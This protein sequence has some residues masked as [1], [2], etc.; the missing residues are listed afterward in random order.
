[1]GGWSRCRG[2]V[3]GAVARAVDAQPVRLEA[4]YRGH[5]GVEYA[6]IGRVRARVPRAVEGA[7]LLRAVEARVAVVARAAPVGQAAALVRGRGFGFGFGFRVYGWVSGS[8]Q[9]AGSGQGGFGLGLGLTWPEHELGQRS[10]AHASPKKPRSQWHRPS[11]QRPRPLQSSGQRIWL[12]LSPIQP[13]RHS[14][15]SAAVHCP[16]PEQP[17]GHVRT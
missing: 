1:M 15:R 16:L 11:W 6:I 7:A 8:G 2:W 14:H 5:A 12:Q 10:C 3:R 13:S 4:G 17:P 9:G